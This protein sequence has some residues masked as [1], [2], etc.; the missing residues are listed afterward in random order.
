MTATTLAPDTK[1][2]ARPTFSAMTPVRYL[3]ALLIVGVTVAPLLFVILG[4]FRT[5]A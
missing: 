5:N 3:F 2:R 4:G 1:K